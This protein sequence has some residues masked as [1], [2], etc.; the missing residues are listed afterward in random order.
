MV[1]SLALIIAAST[2][3]AKMEEHVKKY[4]RPRAYDTIVLAW[5]SSLA[6]TAS[7]RE[8]AARPTKQQARTGL[9][10]TQSLMTAIK[11]SKCFATLTPNPGLRGT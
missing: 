1:T 9:D 10:C 2:L 7:L 8:K 3:L 6:D 4:V 11:P 5:K